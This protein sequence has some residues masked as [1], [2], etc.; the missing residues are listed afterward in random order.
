MS[1]N[2]FG[3]LDKII[4]TSHVQITGTLDK[5]SGLWSVTLSTFAPGS[6][7]RVLR[8]TGV[9]KTELDAMKAAAVELARQWNVEWRMAFD[10][11][12]YEDTEGG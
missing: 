9:S 10:L 8:A 12:T 6:A 2:V 5:A 7:H 3:P 4:P 11:Q 1:D